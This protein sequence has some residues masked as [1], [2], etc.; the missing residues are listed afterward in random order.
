MTTRHACRRG[1]AAS[2]MALK[3]DPLD[4]VRP[5]DYLAMPEPGA[6][7]AVCLAAVWEH[8]TNGVSFLCRG[9]YTVDWGDGSAPENV[10]SN[11]AV[12]HNLLWSGVSSGTLTAEGFRQAII[13]VTPQAGQQLTH[14]AFVVY[15]GYT[16]GTPSTVIEI[17]ARLPY[18]INP[19]IR[20]S[21]VRAAH[22]LALGTVASMQSFASGCRHLRSVV[23]PPNAFSTVTDF[24][25]C[26]A[27]CHGLR[28][29]PMM[30]TAAATSFDSFALGC[31][32]LEEIPLYNT[33]NVTSMANA[34][35]SCVK[36]RSIP[37]FNTVKVT[38]FA[39][40]FG[41][42]GALKTI[43]ALDFSACTTVS[44]MFYQSGV[45]EIPALSLPVC[46][47]FNEW[48][49]GCARL[50][51]VGTIVTGSGKITTIRAMFYNCLSLEYAPAIT[52]LNACI[53]A[54]IV[55]D[56]NGVLREVPAWDFSAITSAA[57]W[58]NA[59]SVRKIG[60]TGMS[61]TF[62]V[63][64]QNLSATELNNIYTALATVVDKTITVT[65]NFGTTGDDPTIATGKGWTVTG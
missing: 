18:C 1:L 64:S 46:T 26:W 10:A 24:S 12:H 57:T 13:R 15:P 36:L 37:K 42:C 41:S 21:M 38:T 29:L 23:V 19:M 11:T 56:S 7:E 54:D 52:Y 51:K 44:Q 59:C 22:F 48:F 9:G 60:I 55:F 43:P 6:D 14:F 49:N 31:G 62:S 32:A 33:Q 45:E 4:W 17:L 20:N 63:A 47:T 5:A 58:L 28:R 40:A 53:N 30:D 8:G 39:F 16:S 3:A 61:A 50:R 2:A 27:T 65:G 35:A 34:F 25:S